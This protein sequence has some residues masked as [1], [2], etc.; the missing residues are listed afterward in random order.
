M[1]TQILTTPNPYVSTKNTSPRKLTC[2]FTETL[3][4]KHKNDAKS[5]S[6]AKENHKEIKN[7]Q[8]RW[9]S[10]IRLL[11]VGL[12]HLRKIVRKPKKAI[13]CVQTLQS[14]AVIENKQKGQRTPLPLDSTS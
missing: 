6:A 4:V 9:M 8:R 10:N 11:F 1:Y 13:Y 7:S 12:V 5:F 3:D 2:Q 14:D